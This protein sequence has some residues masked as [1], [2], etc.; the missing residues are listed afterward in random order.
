MPTKASAM[1]SAELLAALENAK[2]N[3]FYIRN[4]TAGLLAPTAFRDNQANVAAVQQ[5]ILDYAQM[6]YDI[7][8]ALIRRAKE[9]SA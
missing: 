2:T 8:E 3:F 6:Q 9:K 1:T 5:R 7:L 4:L